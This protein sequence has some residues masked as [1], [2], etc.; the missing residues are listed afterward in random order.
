ML[1]QSAAGDA[2]AFRDFYDRTS[3]KLFGII[4]RI[5][6]ERGEA[7]DVLQEVFVTIW[8]KAAEFD[9]SRASPITWAA[10]IARNRAIDRLRARGSRPSV[11]IDDAMQVRDERPDAPALIDSAGD[12]ARVQAA[13]DALEPR[14]AAAIR[15]CYFEGMTYEVLAA[16]EGVPVGTLKSW[17]RRGMIRMKQGLGVGPS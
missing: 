8:R 14:H 12:V 15:S 2:A 7:E 13:L 6:V 10:T 17:V 1:A 3:A 5:L 11:P 4:L 16:R 9:A